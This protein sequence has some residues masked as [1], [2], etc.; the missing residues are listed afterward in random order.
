MRLLVVINLAVF[1]LTVF[2]LT[3]LPLEVRQQPQ[4]FNQDIP[5]SFEAVPAPPPGYSLDAPRTSV[6]EIAA[7]GTSRGVEVS[8]LLITA[9]VSGIT[10]VVVLLFSEA[11]VR[12]SWLSVWL[13][14]V[15]ASRAR[16]A[17]QPASYL[18]FWVGVICAGWGAMWTIGLMADP[19]RGADGFWIAV[20]IPTAFVLH[21]LV[22]PR[23]R[24]KGRS[25]LALWLE[26]K[27]TELEFRLAGLTIT[28]APARGQE[29]VS[30]P[31]V[32]SMPALD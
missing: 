30:K 17:A 1:G 16:I 11:Q 22:F 6:E 25:L 29:T 15:R 19:P 4:A 9:F 24:D 27:R 5:P 14:N 28:K 23:H 10:S 7:G 8:I 3:Q 31:S 20:A 21:W 12:P 2:Q 26:V 13:A 18:R 32:R